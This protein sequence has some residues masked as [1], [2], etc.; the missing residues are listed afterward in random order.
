VEFGI[1]NSEF[2]MPPAHPMK[3]R[4]SDFGFR[5]C[6]PPVHPDARYVMRDPVREIGDS[7]GQW[8]ILSLPP[9]AAADAVHWR[10]R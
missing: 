6:R 3:F 10:C 2:G 1:R 9:V 8:Q 4:I 5:I 7:K